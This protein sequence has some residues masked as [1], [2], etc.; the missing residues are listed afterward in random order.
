MPG[1]KLGD[2]LPPEVLAVLRILLDFHTVVILNRR[3]S[4]QRLE[5]LWTTLP[6]RACPQNRN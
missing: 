3:V 4:W 5:S 6:T 1:K 2:G